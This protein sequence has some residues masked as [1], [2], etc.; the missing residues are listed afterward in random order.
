MS[1]PLAAAV[2]SWNHLWARGNPP[3]GAGTTSGRP[4]D[5]RKRKKHKKPP[6]YRRPKSSASLPR[7]LHQLDLSMQNQSTTDVEQFGD[8][9]SAPLP[10]T[11]R[12][13]FQ[14]INNLPASRL[15]TKSRLT[16][17]FMVRSAA[18]VF[19]FAET[20][21]Y[22]PQLPE[23]DRWY[24]RTFGKFRV[25]KCRLSF[26]TTEPTRTEIHQ[27]GGS[28]LLCTNGTAD[29]MS[30]SGADPSGLGRWSWMLF[31]GRPH[32]RTRVISAYRPCSSEELGSTYQQHL[33]S[34][35]RSG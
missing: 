12:L 17:D 31:E 7:T 4:P 26:N 5:H 27:H 8:T 16:I 1:S 35:G 20:G 6:K 32:H 18:G 33:R 19:G 21:L 14:N 2:D 11:T 24:E 22:W 23:S 13:L 15:T 34:F 25:S 29:R 3:S 28:G 30:T 10:H 9:F